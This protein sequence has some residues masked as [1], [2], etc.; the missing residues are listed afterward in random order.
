[1]IE[2]ICEFGWILGFRY[3]FE[4]FLLCSKLK[5]IYIYYLKLFI[6]NN[7]DIVLIEKL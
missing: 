2:G 7:C 3:L 4:F 6:D 5:I 1:M